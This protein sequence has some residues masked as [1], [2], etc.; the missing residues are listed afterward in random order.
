MKA[1]NSIHK[2][3]NPNV[4]IF[5]VGN[6]V[7]IGVIAYIFRDY[8]WA[9]ILIGLIMLYPYL[10]ENYGNKIYIDHESVKI[11]NIFRLWRMT[12]TA[13]FHDIEEIEIGQKQQRKYIQIKRKNQ[14]L[15]KCYIN[16]S[17]KQILEIINIF[18]NEKKLTVNDKY[19]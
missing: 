18:E 9:A 3:S 1:R 17:A 15:I 10:S 12:H 2:F 8:W 6:L 4:G 13:P 11:K 7:I 5:I 19:T 14:K 16:L